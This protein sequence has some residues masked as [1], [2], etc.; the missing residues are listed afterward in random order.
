AVCV[1]ATRVAAYLRDKERVLPPL[2]AV[3][4]EACDARAAALHRRRVAALVRGG[5][6]RRL[7]A[8]LVVRSIAYFD[9]ALLRRRCFTTVLR[10]P[11]RLALPLWRRRYAASRGALLA[12]L[13]LRAPSAT[14]CACA[15]R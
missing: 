7:V 13:M 1:A 6:S 15:R 9:D 5:V 4:Y 8:V 11:D 14:P 3:L 2:F 10:P 12:L